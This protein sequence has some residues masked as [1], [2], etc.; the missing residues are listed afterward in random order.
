[1]NAEGFYRGLLRVYPRPYRDERGEELLA[2]LLDAEDGAGSPTRRSRAAEAGTI[3]RHGMALRVRTA[4]LLARHRLPALGLAGVALA[5]IL[6]VLGLHQLM[7]MGVRASGLHGFPAEWGVYVR[8]VDPRW[9][10]HAAWVVVAL[11]LLARWPRAAIAAV[12]TAA[13]LHAWYLLAAAATGGQVPWAGNVGPSWVAPSGTA[14]LSWLVLSVSSALLMGNRR[15]TARAL[16]VLGPRRIRRTALLG[17]LVS[18]AA[19]TSGPVLRA[20]ANE[21]TG[22]PYRIEGPL[23]AMLVTAT[24]LAWSLRR[25]ERGRGALLVLVLLAAAPLVVRWAD[26]WAAAA[27]AGLL[28]AA[29]YL[30]ASLHPLRRPAPR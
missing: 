24:V 20:L 15:R 27:G 26:S 1:M 25:V 12:W 29:G 13:G 11:C 21:V 23:P 17:G 14:E 30:A 9:P 2:T 5:V 28:F 10:V 6:G 18:L 4:G 8:W 3:L 22:P 16:A 7:A 19:V